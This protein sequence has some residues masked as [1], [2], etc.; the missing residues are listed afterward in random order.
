MTKKPQLN[1]FFVQYLLL[2]VFR[3]YRRGSQYWLFLSTLNNVEATINLLFLLAEVDNSFN[4]NVCKQHRPLYSKAQNTA[5]QSP[6]PC[7]FRIHH[8]PDNARQSHT[9]SLV[10]RNQKPQ[11]P[12]IKAGY[13]MLSNTLALRFLVQD[14]I[15]SKLYAHEMKPM[16]SPSDTQSGFIT[17]QYR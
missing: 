9:Y 5:L 14:K 7:C 15:Q 10:S 1:P 17:A 6:G 11:F 16:Q 8:S 2:P 4:F 13:Q 3:Q 12:C